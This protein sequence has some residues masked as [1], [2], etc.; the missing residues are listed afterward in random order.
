MNLEIFF[1][2]KKSETIELGSS[3]SGN[4]EKIAE[5]IRLNKEIGTLKIIDACIEANIPIVQ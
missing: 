1:L 5:I 3:K 4:N 2:K